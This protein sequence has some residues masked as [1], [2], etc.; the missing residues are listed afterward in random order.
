MP[1]RRGL[2]P[3]VACRGTRPSQA[4]QITAP[5]KCFCSAY[6]RDQ[7]GRVDD[8]D[9]WDAGQEPRIRIRA[10]DFSEFLV[11]RGDTPIEDLPLVA[12]GADKGL[13]SMAYRRSL[14]LEHELYGGVQWLTALRRRKPPFQQQRPEA[15]WSARCALPPAAPAPC[16]SDWRS[17][18]AS[19]FTLTSR[20]V[21]R[22]AASAI[23]SA[24]RSSFFGRLD[25]GSDIFGR[26]QP[27]RVTLPRMSRPSGGRRSKPPSR[28]HRSASLQ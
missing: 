13:H 20:M 11:E 22:V 1:S 14:V 16:A 3:V 7:R 27:H 2:P 21:G 15:G 24:S 26:D 23:A 9:A 25:I 8:A 6:S 5:A 19:L 12:H 18:C 17:S 10:G 28:P 4:G